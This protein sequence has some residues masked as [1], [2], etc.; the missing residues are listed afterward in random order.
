MELKERIQDYTQDEF[1][2]LVH[3]IWRADLQQVDHDRLVAHFDSIVDH[4]DG[5]DLIYYSTQTLMPHN[6]DNVVYLLK[7]WRLNNGKPDFKGASAPAPRSHTKPTPQTKESTSTAAMAKISKAESKVDLAQQAVEQAFQTAAERLAAME[8]LQLAGG[9]STPEQTKEQQL[10]TLI[11]NILL[12]QIVEMPI[13]R[14]RFQLNGSGIFLKGDVD[15]ARRNTKS[16]SPYID[17]AVHETVLQRVT[18]LHNRFDALMSNF[19]QRYSE[20]EARIATV[21]P[22]AEEQR[23]RLTTLLRKG[24]NDIP[25]TF[26]SSA[27]TASN[28]VLLLA[29]TPSEMGVFGSELSRLHLATQSAIARFSWEASITGNGGAGHYSDLL[30]FSNR[31]GFDERYGFSLPLS[32]IIPLNSHDWQNISN[33]ESTVELPVRF[34]SNIKTLG[35]ELEEYKHIFLTPTGSVN[36]PANVRIRH[37]TLNVEKRI[38]HFTSDGLSPTTITWTLPPMLEDVSD[39]LPATADTSNHPGISRTLRLPNLIPLPDDI[40][41]DDYVVVFPEESGIAPL[42][43]MLKDRLH[44]AGVTEGQGASVSG[45]WLSENRAAA[46]SVPAPIAEQLRGRVFKRFHHLKL[47][48]WKAIARDPILSVQFS[49]EEIATMLGGTAPSVTHEG[50]RKPTIYL[51]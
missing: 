12:I 27:M 32:E 10:A 26:A 46:A 25:I 43:V 38:Y 24:P 23:I 45:V 44:Y 17:R 14:A 18:H 48:F 15:T 3:T 50:A 49:A 20:L 47:A 35:N 6:V 13:R 9:V 31:L 39:G 34:S 28:Q 2:T 7:H 8:R 16:T 30:Q 40:A 29:P 22:W 11:E 51:T 1:T 37:A 33:V 5:A 41:F 4:P 42:Y 21:M 19:T 36:C